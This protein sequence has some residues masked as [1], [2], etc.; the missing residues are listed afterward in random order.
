MNRQTGE[1]KL[2]GHELEI[3]LQEMVSPIEPQRLQHKG[4]WRGGNVTILQSHTHSLSQ[5]DYRVEELH[6]YSAYTYICVSAIYLAQG[7]ESCAT[8]NL[9]A[10]EQPYRLVVLCSA[11][12]L[13][14]NKY[15]TILDTVARRQL[16]LLDYNITVK[17]VNQ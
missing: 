16:E 6:L 11:A 15:H 2:K 9:S 12:A 10:L 7:Q 5:N 17:E 13:I 3:S 1:T 8:L 4:R 14:Q